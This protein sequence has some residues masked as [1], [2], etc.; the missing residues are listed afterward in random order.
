MRNRRPYARTRA[1]ITGDFKAEKKRREDAKQ[2]I[3]GHCAGDGQAVGREIGGNMKLQK[4]KKALRGTHLII[5]EDEGGFQWLSDG[6]AAY[7]M[8]RELDLTEGNLLAILDIEEDKRVNYTVRATKAPRHIDQC[9]QEQAD[10]RLIPLIS[11]SWAG[12]LITIMATL[13][14]DVAAVLQRQIAPADGKEPLAFA[15]RR[16]VDPETG[17]I[18]Q[19]MVCCFADMLC[20]AIICPIAPKTMAEIWRLMRRSCAVGLQYCVAE[21]K[22]DDE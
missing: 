19:P 7:L 22:E 17:K 10:E 12:E 2:D 18:G 4:V 11:V 8:D 14:G 20:S 6:T 9:P 21:K 1:A 5:F 13:D 15:L 16:G 3:S